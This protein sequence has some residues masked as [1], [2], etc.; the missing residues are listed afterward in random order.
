VRAE[1]V[2]WADWFSSFAKEFRNEAARGSNSFL[3]ASHYISGLT[4]AWTR[5]CHIVE[6][7]GAAATES[8]KTS[9]KDL[10]SY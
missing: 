3:S 10:V 2:S 7:E 8:V 4:M 1:G 9:A 6:L 5:I